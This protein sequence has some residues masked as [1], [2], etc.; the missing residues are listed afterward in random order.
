MQYLIPTITLEAVPSYD[1]WIWHAFFDVV[2]SN[3][4]I[5]V[6]NQSDLFVKHLRGEDPKVQYYI[7]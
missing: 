5:N 3:N 2:G 7:N 1:R 4:D 6:L